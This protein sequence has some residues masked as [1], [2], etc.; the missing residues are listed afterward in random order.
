MKRFSGAL[1]LTVS[2][3]LMA[4]FL[5]SAQQSTPPLSHDC[6]RPVW[7]SDLASQSEIDRYREQVKAYR[8]CIERFIEAQNEAILRHQEAIQRHTEAAE[9]AVKEWNEFL[10]SLKSRQQSRTQ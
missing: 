8:D 10:E 9:A 5:A 6:S 2:F 3:L 4:I 1:V 7:P